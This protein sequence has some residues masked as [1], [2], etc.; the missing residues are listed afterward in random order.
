M[1]SKWD[2]LFGKEFY[3]IINNEERKYMGLDNMDD[4]WEM[5]QFYSKTNLWHKRTSVFWSDCII[6]KIILEEK[7]VS[8]ERITYESITEY[9]I[10]LHTENRE[11]LLPLTARG[12]KKKINATNI[13]AFAPTK[14]IFHFH[15][16]SYDKP[17]TSMSIYNQKNNKSIAI[18]ENDK[19]DTI[20]N[21]SDFHE[22]MKY[23][24]D[25]CPTNYFEKI[26]ELREAPHI[27]VKYKTGDIF[28]SEVD[29]FQYTYGIIIG[30]V[31]EIL[32]WPE[33]PEYHSMRKLMMVPIMVRF[34]DICTKNDNLTVDELE[35]FSLGRTQIC[36]DNDIIWGKHKVIGH[37]E[38]EK[39][40][41]E[42]NLICAK[43]KKHNENATV[44]TYNT[45]VD[46]GLVPYPEKFNLYVEWGMAT[47]IL[48]YEKLSEKLKEYLKEYRSP[49]GG[50]STTIRNI[51]LEGEKSFEYK[52]N[53]L[54]DVNKEMREELFKCLGLSVS[55]DFDEFANKYNGIT[56]E[57]IL[58]KRL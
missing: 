54:N 28:R 48:E 14:C 39:E 16:D 49:H 30:Q 29:R 1:A 21:D 27:T 8:D 6:M 19:I 2:E 50:I 13:L 22:F 12:K 35:K 41:L 25:T 34:F 43:I 10:E 55:A 4:N 32:K 57:E 53:L 52:F 20:R 33:L 45:M 58:K 26:N 42:F 56:K 11:W 15:L 46:L 44:H 9:D 7:R 51:N 24:M 17:L 38:I 40:D 5:T 31:K 18:G 47:T 3:F 37:K 23:Y 36:G